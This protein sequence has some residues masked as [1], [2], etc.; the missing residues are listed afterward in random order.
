MANNSNV[1]RTVPG[2]IDVQNNYFEDN[3]SGN[4]Q[5]FYSLG[6][7]GSIDVSNSVFDNV[8]CGTNTVN[9]Y[10]LN[11]SEDLADCE[12][13]DNVADKKIYLNNGGTIVEV[14]N[15]GASKAIAMGIALG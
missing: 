12:V 7:T 3:T 4:G 9:E 15:E 8:D 1:E 10:V 11:S 6:Y 14:A 5:G 13:A 2:T